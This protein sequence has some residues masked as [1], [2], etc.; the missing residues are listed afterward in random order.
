MYFCLHL[1]IIQS[2][3]NINNIVPYI[4]ATLLPTYYW[5]KLYLLGI[6]DVIADNISELFCKGS[7]IDQYKSLFEIENCGV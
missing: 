4:S 3:F 5:T 2:L 6:S 7:L 1:F